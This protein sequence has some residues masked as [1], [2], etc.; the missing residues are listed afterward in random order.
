MQH[1]HTIIVTYLSRIRGRSIAEKSAATGG[2]NDGSFC[3]SRI[4]FSFI[5]LDF[6][7]HANERGQYESITSRIR[8]SD[9][10]KRGR[11]DWIRRNLNF[12]RSSNAG[13]SSLSRSMNPRKRQRENLRE[14]SKGKTSER[15]ECSFLK[16]YWTFKCSVYLLDISV[17]FALF[18]KRS[19]RY[20][21]I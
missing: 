13:S 9:A 1:Q 10:N 11:G 4:V 15:L 20:D 8:P 3:K 16:K 6:F 12:N 5:S 18:G 7:F 19:L 17:K 14:T 21:Q 2:K